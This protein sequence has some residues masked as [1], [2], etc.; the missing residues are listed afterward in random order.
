MEVT[1][2]STPEVLGVGVSDALVPSPPPGCEVRGEGVAVWRHE[3]T[4]HWLWMLRV[5]ALIVR[6]TTWIIFQ[7][8]KLCTNPSS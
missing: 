1:H 2:D 5:V 4:R 8:I 6:S 7:L 3:K